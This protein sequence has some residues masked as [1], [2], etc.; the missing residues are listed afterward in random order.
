[1]ED[2][3]Q[4]PFSE[5]EF[6]GTGGLGQPGQPTSIPMLRRM[7]SKPCPTL[8]KGFKGYGKLKKWI[9]ND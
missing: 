7:G 8:P 1:M 5:C 3:S 2:Q 4:W 6:I 9:P